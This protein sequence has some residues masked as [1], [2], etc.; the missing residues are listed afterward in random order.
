MMVVLTLV[1]SSVFMLMGRTVE[2]ALFSSDWWL[3]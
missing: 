3:P 1:T 2:L